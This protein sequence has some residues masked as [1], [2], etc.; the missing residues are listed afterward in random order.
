MLQ[1]GGETPSAARNL[2]L[3]QATGDV[4]AFLDADD[5]WP[6]DKLARQIDRLRR[7]PAVDAVWGKVRW[8][9]RQHADELRPADDS[10]IL[11]VFAI[12][13]GAGI[14]RRTV[15]NRIGPLDATLTYAED[16]DF[17]LRIRDFGVPITVLPSVTLYYRRHPNAM[18]SE[19][20]AKE[21]SDMKKA[22][23]RSVARRGASR[24]HGVAPTGV[25]ADLVEEET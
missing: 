6:E 5:L 10:R 22:F 11:D 3:A 23:L 4:I 1:G 19:L 8:F 18:T 13:L 2:A 12:N 14:I 24:S 16:I 7:A 25:L 9:D 17:V 21:R 15:L 20:T